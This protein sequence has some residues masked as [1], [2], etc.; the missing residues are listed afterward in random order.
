MGTYI[1]RGFHPP[2]GFSAL[3]LHDRSPS[4]SGRKALRVQLHLRA[5]V[6]T[7]ELN[8]CHRLILP[9]DLRKVALI[10][11]PGLRGYLRKISVCPNQQL[12]G[13][14]HAVLIQEIGKS[15]AGMLLDEMREVAWR[16]PCSLRNRVS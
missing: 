8:R 1:I 5:R 16:Q 14:I 9:K 10:A 13:T 3:A 15:P 4:R 2:N 7:P 12:A 6:P 11:E